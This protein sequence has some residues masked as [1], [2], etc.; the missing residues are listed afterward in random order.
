MLCNPTVFFPIFWEDNLKYLIS[1]RELS[2]MKSQNLDTN[3]IILEYEKK[4]LS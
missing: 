4:Y 2:K 3:E 1:S